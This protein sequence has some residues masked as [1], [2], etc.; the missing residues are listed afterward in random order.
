MQDL[1]F[2]PTEECREIG[3]FSIEELKQNL[4]DVAEQIRPLIEHF[5][6]A[7]FT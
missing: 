5:N 2:T 6:P 1:D 3:L 7:D 4:D